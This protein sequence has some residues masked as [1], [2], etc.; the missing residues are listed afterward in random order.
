M[1]A[2][3]VRLIDASA[4]R[5][6]EGLRVVEDYVRF[7]LD[8]A[9]AT[10]RLKRFRHTFTRL[11]GEISLSDRLR[12]R[13]TRQDVG[14]GITLDS[15]RQRDDAQSV[16]AANFTRIQESL[17]T[18]EEYS[19]VVCPAISG[20]LEQL[21][22]DSYTIQKIV[23]TLFANKDRFPQRPRAAILD[24]NELFVNGELQTDVCSKIAA[25]FVCLTAQNVS[26]ALFVAAIQRILPAIRES[27]KFLFVVDR[28]DLAALAKADGVVLN[29]GAVSV[30]Q[31]RELLPACCA[32]GVRVEN[33]SDVHQAFLDAADWILTQKRF[34][35]L[36]M[37][38][39]VIKS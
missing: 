19:K 33:K 29:P 7:V 2:N 5:A 28:C 30:R 38:Q 18:L 24:V 4:N 6:R 39:A 16:L 37:I 32:V 34:P 31:A 36:S 15:E 23:Q 13:E 27:N 17:R 1:D 11:M 35:K 21:R 9:L 8:D 22:Y 3:I 20:G 26:D 25:D 10:Q 12:A 14:T